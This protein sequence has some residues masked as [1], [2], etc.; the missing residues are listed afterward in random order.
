M[1]YRTL[2]MFLAL[3][4]MSSS[5]FAKE[6]SHETCSLFLDIRENR[7]DRAY[8]Q[9]VRNTLLRQLPRIGYKPSAYYPNQVNKGDLVF[10]GLSIKRA[11]GW[12]GSSKISAGIK[13]IKDI[14]LSTLDTPT[15]LGAVLPTYEI[16]VEK[17]DIALVRTSRHWAWGNTL[18]DLLAR[19]PS[20]IIT[21]NQL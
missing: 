8:Q 3:A 10:T 21:E 15:A 2:T 6:I 14:H 19:I 4:V 16:E 9:A 1:N 12:L 13:R 5:S 20:C 17:D 11:E 7:V 18:D